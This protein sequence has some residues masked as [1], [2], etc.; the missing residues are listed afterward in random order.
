MFRLNSTGAVVLELLARGFSEECIASEISQSSGLA[1]DIVSADLR[2]FLD[3]LGRS[4][5]LD[6]GDRH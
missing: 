5:L 6:T 4:G 2:A 3:S 1:I